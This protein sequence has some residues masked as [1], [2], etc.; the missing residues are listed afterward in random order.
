MTKEQIAKWTAKW[1]WD[2]GSACWQADGPK[3]KTGAAF[4]LRVQASQSGIDWYAFAT[5][6]TYPRVPI[7]DYGQAESVEAAQELAVESLRDILAHEKEYFALATC[8]ADTLNLVQLR[9]GM[10][11]ARVAA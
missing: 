5:Q 7:S 1:T 8:R 6:R 9:K 10:T 4:H 2:A 3:A 11:P